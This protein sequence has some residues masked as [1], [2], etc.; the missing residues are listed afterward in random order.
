MKNNH[1]TIYIRTT[2]L[3]GYCGAYQ[4]SIKPKSYNWANSYVSH[5]REAVQ[6]VHNSVKLHS[7]YVL[8][9]DKNVVAHLSEVGKH[10][11]KTTSTAHQWIIGQTRLILPKN[12]ITRKLNKT[13]AK[14]RVVSNGHDRYGVPYG[15]QYPYH[16]KWMVP[17]LVDLASGN[18]KHLCAYRQIGCTV[19]NGL[20][21]IAERLKKSGIALC[22]IKHNTRVGD[23]LPNMNVS[24]VGSHLYNYA[25]S[26][27][28][29]I[30]NQHEWFLIKE[31]DLWVCFP[32]PLFSN[33][34]Y[35]AANYGMRGYKY[36]AESMFFAMAK[37]SDPKK[38]PKV[39]RVCDV[40][41]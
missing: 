34:R 29:E 21:Y 13:S 19:E 31:P 32:L 4:V 8:L 5:S 27:G 25:R 28:M 37:R 1:G 6:E 41:I 20:K 30:E 14:A 36:R 23:N 7:S 38:L 12:L 10:G 2:P 26:R 24:K 39:R 11:I 35:V 16:E 9:A 18:N 17:A 3:A 33:M 40:R 15:A 22:L